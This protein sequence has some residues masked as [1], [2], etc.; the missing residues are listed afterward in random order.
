MN[1]LFILNQHFRYQKNTTERQKFFLMLNFQHSQFAELEFE[2][3]T[4]LQLKYP[5][6]QATSN[7][8]VEK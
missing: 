5:M 8:I 1:K 3:L 6:V 4:E 7:L 2:Q